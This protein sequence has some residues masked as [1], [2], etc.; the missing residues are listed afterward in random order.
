M[1]PGVEYTF[2]TMDVPW[3]EITFAF[4]DVWILQEAIN[5]IKGGGGGTYRRKGRPL[6]PQIKK[7]VEKKLGPVKTRKF[8]KLVC[9]IRN[10]KHEETK[11]LKDIDISIS[12]IE[13]M[14][15]E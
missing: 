12:E 3:G 13:A 5:I 14:I 11:E 7:E 15:T 10:Q 4:G 9:F 8:I 1:I 2:G 6:D